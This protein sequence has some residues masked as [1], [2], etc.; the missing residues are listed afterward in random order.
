MH[1]CCASVL[2]RW[3]GSQLALT[4]DAHPVGTTV[5]HAGGQSSLSRLCNPSGLPGR[6]FRRRRSRPQVQVLVTVAAAL[7]ALPCR[8]QSSSLSWPIGACIPAGCFAGSSA[9]ARIRSCGPT[10]KRS[11][12]RPAGSPLCRPLLSFVPRPGPAWQG[13]G[14]AFKGFQRCLT[15]TLLARWETG[16]RDPWLILTDLP[17]MASNALLVWAAGLDRARL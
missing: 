9:W 17:P 14:I 6:Y 11:I 12:F 4:L 7:T 1:R 10:I 13:E 2:R 5:C 8:A 3:E 16:Y 15:L